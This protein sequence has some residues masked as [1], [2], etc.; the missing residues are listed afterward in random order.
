MLTSDQIRAA[1]ALLRWSA[2]K[3]GQK[4]GVHVTTVQRMER[5]SGL[6][7]GTVLTLAK[8]QSALEDAGV[9]FTEQNGGP[10]VCLNKPR[11]TRD[12]R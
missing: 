9:A 3:L 10:G 11:R 2:R 4:S 1:R 12:R 7:G 8:I 5:G 6:V